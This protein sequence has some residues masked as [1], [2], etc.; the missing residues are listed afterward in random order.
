VAAVVV[1]IFT[2]SGLRNITTLPGD[3]SDKT[4]HF[5]GYALLG[6]V[7]LR[8]LARVRWSGVTWL[9]ASAAWGLC[10]VYAA[11]D[12]L[13]QWFVPGR[14]MAFDD[15]LADAAGAAA[16]IVILRLVALAVRRRPGRTL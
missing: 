9:T 8:A 15:W 6:S 12:E 3:M 4:G 7:V 14:T 16:A 5:A 10:L 2:I 1:A 13:H 11:S